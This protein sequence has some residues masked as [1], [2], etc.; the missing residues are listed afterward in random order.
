MDLDALA[1]QQ[2]E[3]PPRF[4]KATGGTIGTTSVAPGAI[5]PET[6]LAACSRGHLNSANSTA[7]TMDCLRV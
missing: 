3:I 4:D 6:L 2:G 1:V 5:E 7:T